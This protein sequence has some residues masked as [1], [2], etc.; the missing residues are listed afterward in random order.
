M[1]FR[2]GH[3][4]L[5]LDEEWRERMPAGSRSVVT[6]ITAPLLSSYGYG[7]KSA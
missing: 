1:R 3:L 7:R 2:S 5:V 6:A 4:E